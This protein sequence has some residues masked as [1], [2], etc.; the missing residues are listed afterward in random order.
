MKV[1][2]FR[3]KFVG[4]NYNYEHFLHMVVQD[5]INNLEYAHL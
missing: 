3:L 5:Q 2:S 4:A 1:A